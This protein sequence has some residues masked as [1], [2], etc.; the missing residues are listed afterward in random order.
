MDAVS[1][2]SATIEESLELENLKIRDCLSG[3]RYRILR[4]N[5]LYTFLFSDFRF[6]FKFEN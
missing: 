2:L 3:E 6:E 5:L 1:R 4:K